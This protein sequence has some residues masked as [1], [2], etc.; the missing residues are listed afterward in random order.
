M[1]SNILSKYGVPNKFGTPYLL[2]I[3]EHIRYVPNMLNKYGMF[4]I[5]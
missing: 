2:N 1:C 4:R 5:C 3:F